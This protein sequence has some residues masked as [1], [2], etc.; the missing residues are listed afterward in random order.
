M[1]SYVSSLE[2]MWKREGRQSRFSLCQHVVV[3]VVGYADCCSGHGVVNAT[4]ILRPIPTLELLTPTYLGS[5]RN[6]R[7]FGSF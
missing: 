4:I 5:Y 3:R 6:W 2:G 1:A 7:V